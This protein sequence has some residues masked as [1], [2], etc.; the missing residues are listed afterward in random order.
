MSHATSPSL[1]GR[2][3]APHRAVR[4][5]REGVSAVPGAAL[6]PVDAVEQRR[7]ATIAGIRGVNAL[8]VSIASLLHGGVNEET[9]HARNGERDI[10]LLR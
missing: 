4:R 6:H 5:H 7:G 1:A 3:A 10:C 2:P 8:H 9:D